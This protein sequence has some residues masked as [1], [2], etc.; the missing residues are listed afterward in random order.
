MP[1]EYHQEGNTK[2]VER[3]GEPKRKIINCFC[4]LDK[5]LVSTSSNRI[6][7]PYPYP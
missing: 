5:I 1:A 2:I 3:E 7:T 6:V 4:D